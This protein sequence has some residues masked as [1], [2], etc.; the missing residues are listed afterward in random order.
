MAAAELFKDAA[1]A[2]GRSPRLVT[3]VSVLVRDGILVE[4]YD[5]EVPDRVLRNAVV[6]DA[7]GATIVPAFVDCHSHLTLPGGAR[8]MEHGT[9]PTGLSVVRV[10]STRS[11]GRLL[12]FP[13]TAVRRGGGNP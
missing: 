3:P 5:G 7:S 12:A 6:T 8:W 2:H 10:R 13:S 4:I 11:A 1:L 9:D